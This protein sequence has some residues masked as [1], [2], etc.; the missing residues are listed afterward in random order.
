MSIKPILILLFC[1]PL[2]AGCWQ[3]EVVEVPA[4]AQLTQDAVGYYCNMTVA[5]HPGPKGQIHLKGAKAPLWFSSARD[6]VA[7][8]ML[9]GESKKIAA[10]YVHDA[11]NLADWRRPGDDAWIEARSAHYV[12]HS[13]MKGGMGQPETVPFASVE[14]A[15]SFIAKHGGKLVAWAEIPTGYVIVTDDHKNHAGS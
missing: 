6:T 11:G 8:T 15:K 7:F 1:L 14:K 12:I 5:D 13:A 2:V 10:I 3:D 4:P 9:P